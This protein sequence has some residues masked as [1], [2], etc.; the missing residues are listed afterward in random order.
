MTI[1]FFVIVSLYILYKFWLGEP[2]FSEFFD[3]EHES[4]NLSS[5][6]SG[7]NYYKSAAWKQL[8]HACKD[9]DDWT[10]QNCGAAGPDV[11]LHADHRIPRARGG[12]DSLR[13][14]Q[15]LCVIC[16]SFKHGHPVGSLAYS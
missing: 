9:R 7:R 6:D 10:C 2:F 13:N 14:L 8:S 15:T 11:E 4:Q 1:G 16:H 5:R 3:D 12:P